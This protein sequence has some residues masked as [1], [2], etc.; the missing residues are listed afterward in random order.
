MKK[1]PCLRS[2]GLRLALVT[3][4]GCFVFLVAGT[5]FAQNGAA[6]YRAHCA[7]CRDSPSAHVPAES[8]LRAMSE[9]QILGALQTGV[10]KTVG[11]SLTPQERQAVATY[12]AASPTSPSVPSSAFC[13]ANARPFQYTSSAPRWDGWSTNVTNTRFQDSAAAGLTASDVPKLKLK[14][15]FGLGTQ[16]E[17]RSQPAVAGGRLFFGTETGAVYSL[18]AR[19]GCIYWTSKV[20]GSFRSAAVLGQAGRGKRA[21]VY[22]GAGHNMYALDAARG[23]VLRQVPVAKHLAAIVTAAPL[24][25]R[26]VL[27]VAVSSFEEALTP[28]PGYKCC[29]FRGSVVALMADTGKQ[30]WKTYTIPQTPRPTA[31]NKAGTQMYGPSGAAVWSTPT[32]DEKRNVVYVATGDNY[33]DPATTTSDAVLALNAKTGAVLWSRQMTSGDVYNMACSIPGGPNCPPQPGPDF[34]FGESPILV[35]LPN[36]VREL[37]IGQKSGLVYALDPDKK[38]ELLWQTR[39]GKGGPL[40]GVQWGSATDGR[41]VYVAVSDLAFK[42]TVPDKSSAQGY[43]LLLD[44]EQGGGLFSL[45]LSGGE[46]VWSAVP[47]LDCGGREG[48]SPAQSQAVSAIRGV[49]FS[50]SMDGHIRAYSTSTGKI[51]W[52]VDTAHEYTTLNGQPARGGSLDG[53]GPVIVGGMLYVNSGYA[54]F[55]GMPGN[56]LLAFSVDGK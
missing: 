21:A 54:H 3:G 18:D 38:G 49:V 19:S 8:A 25:H 26:G 34:D 45:S 11:S 50:G 32:F 40:G 15:A 51:L 42:G 29:T 47:R 56:V 24:L 23:N 39:V 55:G 1:K 53:P 9:V 13:N 17:A 14:W 27:Y 28:M 35:S 33:S 2:C 6:V 4:F 16:S 20:D 12:L 5:A 36:G 7:S 43:R 31:K 22:I 52:D 48:C 30:L 41:N 44:P 10:M 37:V 46:K